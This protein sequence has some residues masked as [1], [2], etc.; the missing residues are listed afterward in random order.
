MNLYNV[1]KYAHSG[2][3]YIVLVLILLAIIQALV[4]WQGKK[5]Y[6]DGNRKLNLL[7]MISAHIQLV[8]GLVLYF[9]SPMV[10]FSG[11]V[12]KDPTYR[13]W[14]VEHLVM[15]IFA[16]ILITLG[17]ARSKRIPEA[18]GKHRAI[19]IFYIL[20]TIIILSAI[21]Q[22]GRPLFSITA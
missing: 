16:I 5:P 21:L 2:W 12:M 9:V 8:L 1:L 7:A 14:T 11:G 19:A 18:W 10:K 3:R 6:T 15:M 13:Y 17:H 4:G 22:S 20:A